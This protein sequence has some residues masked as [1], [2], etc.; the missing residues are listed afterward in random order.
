MTSL[1]NAENGHSNDFKAAPDGS[2]S[3]ENIDLEKADT[4]QFNFDGAL[5]R[6]IVIRGVP[7]F[8]AAD[9]CR[10][11]GLLPHKG[12]C[13]RHLQKLDDDEKR[14]VRRDAV[15]PA[16][17][18][19][20]GGVE[21]TTAVD[22]K[23]SNGKATSDV[24]DSPAIWVISESGLYTL[25]LRSKGATRKGTVAHRFRGW[26]TR[27]ILPA[28][29]ATGSYGAKALPSDPLMAQLAEPGRY[30]VIVSPDTAPDVRRTPLDVAFD[31]RTVLNAE[32][33]VHKTRAVASRW[34]HLQI[35]R[36]SGT[37]SSDGKLFKQLGLEIE[38]ARNV[39]EDW[40]ETFLLPDDDGHERSNEVDGG[41]LTDLEHLAASE[42]KAGVDFA[43][44]SG[45]HDTVPLRTAAER[46]TKVKSL[47][48]KRATAQLSDRELAQRVGV[49]PQTVGNIRRRM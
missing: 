1:H 23:T 24:E 31:E 43:H 32:L 42:K 35:M 9:V 47:L 2:K 22:H 40:L 12:S 41:M 36:L 15:S 48:S 39:A 14:Q 5:I 13:V 33:L 37:A 30:V 49:S 7:W 38:D 4:T 3:W 19:F 10:A 44:P 16:T 26:V 17:S 28:I 20:N 21:D 34:E 6:M 18:P 25:I 11:L 45:A 8:L 27:D 29:R 46:R